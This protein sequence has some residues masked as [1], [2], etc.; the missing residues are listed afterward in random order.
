MALYCEKCGEVLLDDSCI[1]CGSVM[2]VVKKRIRQAVETHGVP[3]KKTGARKM[4]LKGLRIEEIEV[5]W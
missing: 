5:T 3:A 2:D 1:R 4:K